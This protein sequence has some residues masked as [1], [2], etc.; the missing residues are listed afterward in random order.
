[1]EKKFNWKEMCGMGLLAV[2]ALTL[3]KWVVLRSQVMLSLA[4]MIATDFW[5]VL[6]VL[7]LQ[8]PIQ[9]LCAL[10]PSV[11]ILSFLLL[12]SVFDFLVFRLAPK[13]FEEM[14]ELF[15]TD[16]ARVMRR[17]LLIY[18]A[19]WILILVFAYSVIGV[20]MALGLAILFGL[21][22]VVAAIPVALYL[23][24]QVQ[25]WYRGNDRRSSYNFW[26][27]AML[28][29]FCVSVHLVGV[30]FLLFVFPALSM[31]AFGILLENK[32][33]ICQT[34]QKKKA[35]FDRKRMRKIIL[36]EE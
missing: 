23:G 15:K 2:C 4:G 11:T 20:P 12:F 17:G 19:R 10:P 29:M 31:G 7:H 21:A 30:T 5:A 3:L 35:P 34:G 32:C 13:P 25:Q 36:R 14:G 26:I 9:W 18:F 1:M 33:T 27:G 24:E 22:D 28:M 6:G 16:A 8:K